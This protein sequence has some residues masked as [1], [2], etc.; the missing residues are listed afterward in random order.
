MQEM[1]KMIM[2]KKIKM[3]KKIMNFNNVQKKNKTRYSHHLQKIK[4]IVQFQH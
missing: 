4:I 2:I 1:N 3:K